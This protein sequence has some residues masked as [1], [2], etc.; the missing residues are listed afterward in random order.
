MRRKGQAALSLLFWALGIAVMLA[1]FLRSR[2]TADEEGP[3][4][5]REASEQ[6]RS[7]REALA[8][9]DAEHGADLTG[10]LVAAERKYFTQGADQIDALV[11][12][13]RLPSG[14]ASYQRHC[15][16]CH[17]TLA[18]GAGPAARHLKPRPRVFTS[19]V[20]KFTSTPTGNPPLR[21]DL[22]QTLTR[23]LAGSSMP[24]FRL[25]PDE[26][27]WDLVEYVRFSAMKGTFENLVLEIAQDDEEVPSEEDMAD[28]ADIVFERWD[29]EELKAVYPPIPEPPFSESSVARGREVFTDPAGANCASCHGNTGVGDGPSA[30]NF[31]DDWGYPIQPR[32]LTSGVFRAGDTSADLYRTIMTGINGTPMPSYSA[33]IPPEDIWALVHFIQSLEVKQ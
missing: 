30:K 29:P 8:A 15:F 9:F 12:F 32:D 25:L 7:F 23:G 1:P 26:L 14:Q 22:Y 13:S 31:H 28:Y 5:V 19:G 4:P 18:D 2:D 20:F 3:D 33:T 16:G 11:D 10:A 6:D 27:R 21:S 17:G 24:N